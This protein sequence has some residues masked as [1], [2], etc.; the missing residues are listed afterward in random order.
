MAEIY[1]FRALHYNA[2]KV[3]NLSSV[4]TQPYDKITPEMQARYYDLSSYNLV[5]IIRGRQNPT[6]SP[7]D[8]VYRRAAGDFRH[9]IENGILISESE[10]AIYPYDQEYRVPG[11][12]KTT[13]RRRGFIALCRLEDYSRGIIHR[14]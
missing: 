9:W 1:P 11:E 13:N 2:K 8:S 3:G 14:H 10:P 5:R 4:V 12:P 6:D 7:Q